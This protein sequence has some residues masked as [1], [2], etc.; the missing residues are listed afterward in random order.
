V[1]VMLSRR[2]SSRRVSSSSKAAEVKLEVLL[3]PSGDDFRVT[4]SE[5]KQ[6][7]VTREIDERCASRSTVG[8]RTCGCG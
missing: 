8:P 5:E 2:R 1:V 4:L 7:R 6:A 3:V